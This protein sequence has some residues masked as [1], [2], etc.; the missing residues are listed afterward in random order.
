MRL[1]KLAAVLVVGAIAVWFQ[2]VLRAPSVRR[3]KAARRRARALP[4][5]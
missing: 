4:K 1:L 3:R 5:S 2:A